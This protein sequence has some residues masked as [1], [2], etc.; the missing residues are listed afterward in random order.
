FV[1]EILVYAKEIYFTQEENFSWVDY[2]DKCENGMELKKILDEKKINTPKLQLDLQKLNSEFSNKFRYH[3]IYNQQKIIWD[4]KYNIRNEL[5]KIKEIWKSVLFAE[6]EKVIKSKANNENVNKDEFAKFYNEHFKQHENDWEINYYG[7]DL[8]FF[9]E[10]FEE[11]T[12]DTPKKVD[13]LVDF[14]KN[15]LKPRNAIGD[16]LPILTILKLIKSNSEDDLFKILGLN[17]QKNLSPYVLSE[18]VSTFRL[19]CNSAEKLLSFGKNYELPDP[20]GRDEV[21]DFFRLLWCVLNNTGALT[22]RINPVKNLK[23]LQ[24]IF[25]YINKDMPQFK[26]FFGKIDNQNKYTWRGEFFERLGQNCIKIYLS[27]KKFGDGDIK[28]EIDYFRWFNRFVLD[29]LKDD[30]LD[31]YKENYNKFVSE[32]SSE[33]KKYNIEIEDIKKQLL[34]D[35]KWLDKVISQINQ[36]KS[37]DTKNKINESYE[38]EVNTNRSSSAQNNLQNQPMNSIELIT[39][40]SYL[41]LIAKFFLYALAVIALAAFVFSIIKAFLFLTILS[42]VF[43]LGFAFIAYKIKYKTIDERPNQISTGDLNYQ[44][45]ITK[46]KNNELNQEPETAKGGK[47]KNNNSFSP[48]PNQK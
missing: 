38:K 20:K 3:Y 5:D 16:H 35:E 22:A 43:C 42:F 46:P 4:D 11:E 12:I 14:I 6:C 34:F 25:T 19:N 17:Q 21:D 47:D 48:N 18:C 33:I 45:E 10:V 40:I 31:G 29:K 32:F 39:K 44:Q 24:K 23:I 36:M 37:T 9:F 15:D 1:N 28:I 41:K 27:E 7:A 13:Q 30:N 8:D 26:P 2:I